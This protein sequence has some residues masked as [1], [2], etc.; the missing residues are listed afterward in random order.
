[1][2]VAVLSLISIIRLTQS[3]SVS[4]SPSASSGNTPDPPYRAA[5]VSTNSS[6]HFARPSATRPNASIITATL[7]VLAVRTRSSP[8]S[9]YVSPVSRFFANKKTLPLKGVVSARTR[10]SSDGKSFTWPNAL[11]ANNKSANAGGVIA[12]KHFI[13]IICSSSIVFRN[14]I[15]PTECRRHYR[16]D[17]LFRKRPP[18]TATKSPL[19]EASEPLSVQLVFHAHAIR[20]RGF[21]ILGNRHLELRGKGRRLFCFEGRRNHFP[22]ATDRFIY[23]HCDRAVLVIANLDLVSVFVHVASDDYFV[24]RLFSFG[25]DVERIAYLNAYAFIFRRVIAFFFAL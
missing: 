16:R 23:Y 10:A 8:S 13:L 1:M 14:I 17:L 22:I 5:L 20:Q 12:L 18:A 24:I 2:F 3:R 21:A 15:A 6:V 25:H 4:R 7:M 11:G 9:E 19:P